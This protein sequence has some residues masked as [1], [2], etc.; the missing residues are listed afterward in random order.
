[1]HSVTKAIAGHSDAQAGAL[2]TADEA[3]ADRLRSQRLLTGA[4][5]GSLDIWLALRGIRT[6]PLRAERSA[7]TAMRVAQWL[8]SRGILTWYPGL[9]DHPGHDIAVRQ[10]SGF[11]SMLAIDVGSEAEATRVVDSVQVFTP[12]TSLGGVESLIEH[13]L[14]SDPTMDPGVVRLSIGIED[15]ADLIADLAHAI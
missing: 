10:M 6:L 14:R 8:V 15:P 7:S 9:P 4:I 1:M 12:A 11:G 13:R 5:P 2:V 3:D